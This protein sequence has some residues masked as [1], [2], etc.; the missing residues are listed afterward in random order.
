MTRN[1]TLSTF[2]AVSALTFL[3]GGSALAKA[4][5][6]NFSQFGAD[7]TSLG[8]PLV[9]VT[10]G[11]VGVTITSP[12]G[13][14]E[15]L[16][17]GN[18][19]NGIFPLTAPILFDGYGPGAVVLTFATGIDSLTLAGQANA[20]GAYTE[21]ALAYSG[22]TLVATAIA[23]SLITSTMQTRCIKGSSRF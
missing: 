12:N 10:T 11:G 3:I 7:G 19:W 13:S 14:F 16:Q 20:Y 2:L 8:S 5:T 22:T 17:E 1:R 23:T 6:I 18:D 4:D 9:G 21:T 15:I